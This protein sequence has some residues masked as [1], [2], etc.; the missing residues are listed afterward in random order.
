[1]LFL[2]RISVFF[3]CLM[4]F[5]VFGH[6]NFVRLDVPE[7]LFNVY[8]D[9]RSTT[10]VHNVLLKRMSNCVCDVLFFCVF[11]DQMLYAFLFGHVSI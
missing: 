6:L 8:V 7:F 3:C 11:S 9:H 4:L 1:M 5:N 10:F 2:R